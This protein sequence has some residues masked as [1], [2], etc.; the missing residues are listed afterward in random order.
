MTKLEQIALAIVDE[1]KGG[2]GETR[3]DEIPLEERQQALGWAR[4]AMNVAGDEMTRL[5][6][7]FDYAASYQSRVL[8]A[9]AAYNQVIVVAGYAAFFAIWSATANDLPRWV[10]LT[11]A[12]LMVVSVTL[13][14]GWTIIGMVLIQQHNSRLRS[15]INK[16]MEDYLQRIAAAE[17]RG[18]EISAKIH[19]FWIPIVLAA[20]IPA[21]IATL[22]LS[23]AALVEVVHAIA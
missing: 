13:Y 5:R 7:F 6:E 18:V 11:C 10:T 9:S 16:G 14:V 1:I 23:G 2:E 20:A 3:W 21:A 15:E 17:V 22:L 19:R 4:A 8:D 12:A